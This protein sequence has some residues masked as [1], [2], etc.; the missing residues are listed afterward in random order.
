MAHVLILEDEPVLRAS[1][2]RAVRKVPGVATAEAGTVAEAVA[3]LD[4]SPPD[5]VLSDLDL[6]DGSGIELLGELARR[7]R[8]VPVVYISAFLRDFVPR[9]PADS[10]VELRSKP[11]T[12]EELRAIVSERLRGAAAPAAAFSAIDYLQLAATGRRSVEIV[13]SGGEEELGRVV[14]IAGEVWH[15]EDGE[16][17]GFEA[18][19]RLT[20]RADAS[21][22]C[23]ACRG[24]PPR[25]LEGS[26]EL[27]LLRVAWLNDE[28]RGEG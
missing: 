28:G 14:V 18:F 25:T 20:S 21:A 9:I 19:R 2:A 26:L 10:G 3:L 6:P 13:V 24:S 1:M 5:L 11:V 12:P 22:E 15:A 7:G 4:A 17:T 8:A 27:L 23:R 16:G